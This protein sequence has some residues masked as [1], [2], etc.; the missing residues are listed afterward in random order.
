MWWGEENED[1]GR[2]VKK[3]SSRKKPVSFKPGE[4]E[5]VCTEE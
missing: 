3:F 1:T 2:K 4:S 5:S